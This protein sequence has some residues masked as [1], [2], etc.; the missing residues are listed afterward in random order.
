MY[1]GATPRCFSSVF[2]SHPRPSTQTAEELPTSARGPSTGPTNMKAKAIP[3]V[4]AART[5]KPGRDGMRRPSPGSRRKA[6][7]LQTEKSRI[8]IA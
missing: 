7:R 2:G 5:E 6:K 8:I 4:R 3:M 1:A